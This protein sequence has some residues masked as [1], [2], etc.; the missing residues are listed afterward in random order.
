MREKGRGEEEEGEGMEKKLDLEVSRERRC[1]GG[2]RGRRKQGK[3]HYE[4]TTVHCPCRAG[5][6]GSFGRPR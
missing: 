2:R 6:L 5:S 3:P 4:S 1:Y